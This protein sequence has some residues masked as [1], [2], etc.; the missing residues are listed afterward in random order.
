M[1]ITK[2]NMLGG[3]FG[4]LAGIFLGYY[5]NTTLIPFWVTF[6]VILGWWAEEIRQTAMS[7]SSRPLSTVVN[8]LFRT[9]KLPIDLYQFASVDKQN[10]AHVTHLSAWVGWIVVSVWMVRQLLAWYEVPGYATTLPLLFTVFFGLAGGMVWKGYTSTLRERLLEILS[11]YGFIPLFF[12]SL[13]MYIRHTVGVILFVA[14]SISIISV[15]ILSM[16]IVVPIMVV[17]MA[18]WKM[19]CVANKPGHWLCLGVTLLTTLF[20]WK[21]LSQYF[22]N[23]LILWSVA[24]ITGM[25]SGFVTEMVRRVFDHFL[26]TETGKKL[27][28]LLSLEGPDG[29]DKLYFDYIF[30][31]VIA[32]FFQSNK[33]GR[34][35]RKVCL[36]MT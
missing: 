26:Q 33:A 7:T 31:S 2:R 27:S 9:V 19:L 22:D 4:G 12:Y 25:A 15:S 1:S 5:V 18:L 10:L 36:G 28:I 21:G 13:L 30:F 16:M 8:F 17:V 32:S 29:I 20:S 6:G 23:L 11:Q 35:I 24:L 3:F 14:I 34:M